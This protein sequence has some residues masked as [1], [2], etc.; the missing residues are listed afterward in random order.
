MVYDN[1]YDK[2]NL[3]LNDRE[4]EIELYDEDTIHFSGEYQHCG[5]CDTEYYSTDKITMKKLCLYLKNKKEHKNLIKKECRE[6]FNIQL[7]ANNTQIKNLQN[8]LF[9]YKKEITK[10]TEE[11]IV[12]KK[13]IKLVKKNE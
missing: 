1:N 9:E 11:N 13:T 12:L 5:S 8:K 3:I 7:N 2:V 4:I 6:E 10:L